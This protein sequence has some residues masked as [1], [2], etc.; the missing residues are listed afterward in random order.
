MNGQNTFGTRV[1][2]EVNRQICCRG[3]WESVVRRLPDKATVL[4]IQ[5]TVAD[6]C[7]TIPSSYLETR[8]EFI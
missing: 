7:V 6:S 4:W 1:G 3:I 8:E 2:M 5:Y